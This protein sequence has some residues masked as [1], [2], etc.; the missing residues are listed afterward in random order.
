MEEEVAMIPEDPSRHSKTPEEPVTIDLSAEDVTE[1][2]KSR[3]AGEPPATVEA[4][5]EAAEQA[6]T[7]ESTTDAADRP[8]PEAETAR[9]VFEPERPVEKP[10]QQP[11]T[12]AMIAAGIFGGIVALAG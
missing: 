9:P 12:T 10:R 4:E 7:V 2:E 8:Q 11:A 5:I 1:A 6:E 3:L